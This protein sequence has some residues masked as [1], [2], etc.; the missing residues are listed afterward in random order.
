MTGAS[1]TR[2][3]AARPRSDGE[4]VGRAAPEV[5]IVG[6]GICGL[7]TAVAL[8]RRGCS[9]T[10]YEAASAYEPV[11]AGILLQT[12]AMLVFDHLGLADAIREAGNPLEGG[13]LRA[14][15]GRYLTRFDLDGMDRRE[16]GHGFVT[17]HRAD[18]QEL[19]L[20]AL[21]A[22]VR[23]GKD[24]V[25]V[26]ETDPPVARFAD[27]TTASPDLLVGADGIH[28]AVREAVAPGVEP[29]SIDGVAYRALVDLD[30]PAPYDRQG[31]EV[32]GDGTYTGG[33]PVGEDR[34][35][36]FATAP[37]E[38]TVPDA[39]PVAVGRALREYLAGYPEPVPALLD[40]LDPA[41]VV[42]TDLADLP[43]LE[44]WSRDRVVIAGDAAH[45]MLP[46]AGQGAAQ[47]IEDGLALADAIATHRDH[48][49]AF[50][51]FERE[52]RARADRVRSGSHRL[53]RLGTMQS[54]L[55]CRLRNLVVDHVPDA[56]VR[57]LR[58]RQV[59]GTSLPG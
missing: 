33:S 8:E 2:A 5:A 53:G 15:D 44:T 12:N 41:E 11:G 28:S 52:R 9:P 16:F 56:M 55:G 42:V 59:A 27:G 54:S 21:D 49:A 10:V 39:P 50:D 31:F 23:T 32:W 18:L 34:F 29:R 19:L 14:P 7:T 48:A 30:V 38:L 40:A 43:A 25:A 24:C 58:R 20:D 47:A 37:A 35:Y 57:R 3:D 17:V 6:G 22:E 4:T 46:F 26:D 51:A 36:W 1:T 13:G 45:A